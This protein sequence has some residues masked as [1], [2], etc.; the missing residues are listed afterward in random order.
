MEIKSSVLLSLVLLILFCS[1]T[2]C[3]IAAQTRTPLVKKKPFRATGI[4]S[5]L[6][7]ISAAGDVIGLEIFLLNSSSGH[8]AMVQIAEGPIADPVLV[9]ARINGN[10]VNFTLPSTSGFEDKGKYTG[11]I[12]A[13]GLLGKFEKET[14]LQLLKRKKS[15]WQ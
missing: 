10:K 2:N 11:T 6:T 9:E 14:K 3:S 15:Y 12:T 1:L 13:R 8:F 4:F 5:N 7:Y